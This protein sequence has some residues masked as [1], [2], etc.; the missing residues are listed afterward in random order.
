MVMQNSLP[1]SDK[2]STLF[3][4]NVLTEWLIKYGKTVLI[5]IA[6]LAALLV[7]G[8]RLTSGNQA[9]QGVEYLKAQKE[10]TQ[11]QTST[12]EAQKEALAKLNQ[13]FQIIPQLHAKYD[14]LIAQEL[15]LSNE[16]KRAEE[17][18]ALA[19]QRIAKDQLPFHAEYS[20]IA[21]LISQGEYKTALERTVQLKNKMLAEP[22]PRSFGDILFAYT[23]LNQA[24]L[25]QQVGDL[26]GEK[27]SWDELKRYARLVKEAPPADQ[28]SPEAFSQMLAQFEMGK[29][30]L[31]E[32]MNLTR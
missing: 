29:V 26:K 1:V 19:L 12:G 2:K 31:K 6:C 10:F 4:I 27:E 3:D 24:L 17:F 7:I 16:V 22:A 21:L 20:R 32:Y 18:A 15:L 9:K 8:L 11:F 30:S 13:V 25:Y 28:F 14:G 23:L 5:A